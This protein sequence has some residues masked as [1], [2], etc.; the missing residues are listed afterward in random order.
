MNL[1]V[2]ASDIGLTNTSY[3]LNK[4]EIEVYV[5]V[6]G[7]QDE[8][9]VS[10]KT[11]MSQYRSTAQADGDHT[12]HLLMSIVSVRI[13]PEESFGDPTDSQWPELEMLQCWRR[14]SVSVS[15]SVQRGHS[16]AVL[17]E[18]DIV[19]QVRRVQTTP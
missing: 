7:N 1:S 10:L 11:T 8:I 19:T 17:P 9:S 12:D 3:L 14:V 6:T 16:A 2:Y 5:T 15:V 13:C 4:T 18:I